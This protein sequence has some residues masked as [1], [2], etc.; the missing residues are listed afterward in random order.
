MIST[1]LSVG[2]LVLL[3]SGNSVLLVERRGR[4]WLC[5]FT[6]WSTNR[7]EIVFSTVW[8]RKSGTIVTD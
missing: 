2:L 5:Q 1:R 3:P 8:L 6:P 4:E 7:G